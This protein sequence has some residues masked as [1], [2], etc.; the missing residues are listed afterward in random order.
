MF[1]RNHVS[2]SR[3][4]KKYERAVLLFAL[5]ITTCVHWNKIKQTRKLAP[6]YRHVCCRDGDCRI[7]VHGEELSAPLLAV[8]RHGGITCFIVE[9]FVS[10]NYTYSVG[11]IYIT[12]MIHFAWLHLIAPAIYLWGFLRYEV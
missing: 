7:D 3:Q 9:K 5:Y 12:C 1:Y 8:V 2:H 10:A 4:Y 11:E 6:H